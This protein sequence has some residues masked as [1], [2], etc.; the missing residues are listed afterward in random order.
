[1]SSMGVYQSPNEFPGQVGSD[2][3][4][5]GG[6]SLFLSIGLSPTGLNGGRLAS[7]HRDFSQAM[8]ISF[9]RELSGD[10]GPTDG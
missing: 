9:D 3:T 7:P 8:Y 5:F 10:D 1:M 2:M 6:F 4:G